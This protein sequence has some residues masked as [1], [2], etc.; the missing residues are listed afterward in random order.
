MMLAENL[1]PVVYREL[2]QM[3]QTQAR[4]VRRFANQTIMITGA[5]GLLGRSLV[6]AFLMANEAFDLH[7]Q[8][9]AIARN[10]EKVARQYG[11]LVD[12]PELT[13]QYQDLMTPY[14]K[15]VNPNYIFHTAAVTDGRRL[16]EYP[17][18]TFEAQFVGMTNVLKLAKNTQAQVVYLSSME[19][20]GQPFT[21]GRATE[22]DVGY[23]DPLVIRNGYPESKRANEFMASAFASEFGVRVVNARLAQTFGPGVAADDHRVFAQFARSVIKGEDI[24]LQT[25]GSSSGNYSYLYDT[26]AGLLLLAVK[27]EAGQAY[28]IV[29][30]ATSITIKQLAELVATFNDQSHVVIDIPADDP[31]Y[32]P[33][34]SLKLS[35]EK[36]MALGWQ[37]T[38]GLKAMFAVLIES[39]EK[40]NA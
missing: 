23:V 18:E 22:K 11:A 40:T 4:L 24:V 29:N 2:N 9:I 14:A 13:F 26:L 6:L 34:V 30:E 20:Y 36:L 27:G 19:I 37:P 5:T 39:W 1:N 31:G 16:K 25:D 15:D 28:N 10:R 21:K 38:K 33:K 17:V 12:A 3:V 35:A 32:A 8:V 7:I